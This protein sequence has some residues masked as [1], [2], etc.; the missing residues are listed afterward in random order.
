MQAAKT[1]VPWQPKLAW[2]QARNCLAP[3]GDPLR[4]WLNSTK[5]SPFRAFRAR[6]NSTQPGCRATACKNLGTVRDQSTLERVNGGSKTFSDS[7]L[8]CDSARLFSSTHL[9]SDAATVLH[10]FYMGRPLTF[11]PLAFRL[12]VSGALCSY[13]V[14]LQFLCEKN[15]EVLVGLA[16]LTFSTASASFHMNCYRHQTATDKKNGEKT[17]EKTLYSA[18]TEADGGKKTLMPCQCSVSCSKSS[19]RCRFTSPY[20]GGTLTW[21]WILH[22]FLTRF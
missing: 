22:G 3:I 1:G 6:L 15:V 9:E 4:A 20:S 19:E 18:S 5:T 12:A 13:R 17:T 16:P 2:K 11:F 10:S 21:S 7:I 14:T 8:R